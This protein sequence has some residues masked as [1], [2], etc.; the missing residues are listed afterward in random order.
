MKTFLLVVTL[1][2]WS[3][4]PAL[5]QKPL[6]R[7]TKNPT[8]QGKTVA[9]G[10]DHDDAYELAIVQLYNSFDHKIDTASLCGRL[11]AID[12][13]LEIDQRTSWVEAAMKS[14][15]F[16][17]KDSIETDTSY[18]VSVQITPKDLSLFVEQLT[19]SNKQFGS[20]SLTRARFSREQGDLLSAVQQYAK[21]LNELMPSI[22]RP[23]PTEVLGGEDLANTI[24]AEYI[25]AL[26]S[27][28]CAPGRLT[29]PMVKGEEIPLELTYRFTAADGKVIANMPVKAG[30]KGPEGKVMM[31]SRFTDRDGLAKVRVMEAPQ[32]DEAE[33][34]ACVDEDVLYSCI[35]ENVGKSL[36]KRRVQGTFPTASIQLKALDPT[37]TFT[38]ALDSVDM[39]Q[40]PALEA[41]L[42]QHGFIQELPDTA[43]LE[44]NLEYQNQLQGAP[45]RHGDY[46]LATY[47]C[48][49]NLRILVRSTREVLSEYK[50]KDFD[51]LQPADKPA[52]KVRARAVGEMMKQVKRELPEYLKSVNYDKRKVVFK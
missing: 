35:P 23:L 32:S 34:W 2:V 13:I 30:F 19:S 29:C 15:Y 46:V 49:L 33:V 24:Y 3:L 47:R 36:L 4:A 45:E 5:A 8:G 44:V 40:K 43:D 37:P 27:L 50:I 25:S 39:E 42:K 6:P 20:E 14:G 22:H 7:W 18:W 26:D 51:I 10:D 41:L 48:G 38:V 31:V 52:E 16:K 9:M 11:M 17:V 21:G 28:Q 1:A 12:S